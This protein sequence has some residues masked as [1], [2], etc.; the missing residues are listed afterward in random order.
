MEKYGYAE[1]KRYNTSYHGVLKIVMGSSGSRSNKS[2]DHTYGLAHDVN[3][4]FF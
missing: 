2:D 3:I 4:L 1:H